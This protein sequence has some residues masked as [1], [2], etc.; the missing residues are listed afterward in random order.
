VVR[1]SRDD[2]SAIVA[3]ADQGAGIPSELRER[4]FERFDQAHHE[5]YVSGLGLGL[6][7]SRQ[8]AEF[9][10]GTLHAEFPA[11]GG[12]CFILTLPLAPETPSDNRDPAHRQLR[13]V[14]LGSGDD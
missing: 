13:P 1:V 14:E 2:R 11:E 6:Y 3:I 9:H 10:G 8:V 4:L 7:I 12:S 5:N